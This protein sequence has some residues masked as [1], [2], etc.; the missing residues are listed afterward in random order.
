MARV[1]LPQKGL[2][3][4]AKQLPRSPVAIAGSAS[5]AHP[6]RPVL[7]QSEVSTQQYSVHRR[8]TTSDHGWSRARSE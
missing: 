1:L 4:I 7:R 8:A 3:E 5:G 6:E 2:V